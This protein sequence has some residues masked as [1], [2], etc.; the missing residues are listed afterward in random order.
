MLSN[1]SDGPV[2]EA[3]LWISRPRQEAMLAA[4]LVLPKAMRFRALVDTGASCTCVNQEVIDA[5]GLIQSGTTQIHTPSTGNAPAVCGV[6]DAQILVPGMQ[7]GAV[8]LC[9]FESLPV[10]AANLSS[11]SIDGLIGR[12]LLA[13]AVLIYH[14]PGVFFSLSY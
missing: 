7:D 3:V 14:G 6:Y 2:L 4:G 1:S 11:Q 8:P 9:H 12:D 13:H 10:V 5:V